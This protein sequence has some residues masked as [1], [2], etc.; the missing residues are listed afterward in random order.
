MSAQDA[1]RIGFVH[2][3]VE[4]DQL[5]PRAVEI[6]EMI[7]KQAPLAVQ[8]SKAMA[9]FWRQY[10]IGTSLQM[11]EYVNKVVL[12]SDDAKEGPRAFAEKR[13]PN[14]QGK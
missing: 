2:D 13:A 4:P 9:Q 5:M 12:G 7:G 11:G 3:V 8:G 10:A 14:W 1:H 6:A